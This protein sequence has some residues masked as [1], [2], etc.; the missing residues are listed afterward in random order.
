LKT[1]SELSGILVQG[2][3]CTWVMKE[4]YKDIP[5]VHEIT[6]F[7]IN[8]INKMDSELSQ[9][10][11]PELKILVHI[12]CHEKYQSEDK[13]KFFERLGFKSE[14]TEFPCCG[15]GGSMFFKHK[16]MSQKLL[17]EMLKNKD[18]FELIV[19]NS[20]GCI[21]Q[22]STSGKKAVS[23]VELIHFAFM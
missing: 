3:T 10:R 21:I 18:D 14:R 22:L 8:R 12:P 15:F 1:H 4:F 20:P 5:E 23:T 13:T 19:S 11:F 2:A 6:D 7:I 9:N 17:E 16:K